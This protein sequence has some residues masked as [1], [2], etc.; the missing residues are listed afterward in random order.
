MERNGFVVEGGC[1]GRSRLGSKPNLLLLER[2]GRKVAAGLAWSD[3]VPTL[4]SLPELP[5]EVLLQESALGF[6]E[7]WGG[8][9]GLTTSAGERWLL[10]G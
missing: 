8:T 9:A 6:R 5:G 3:R 10:Q 7:V 4:R 1:T 2:Q